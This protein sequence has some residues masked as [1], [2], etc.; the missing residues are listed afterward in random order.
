MSYIT[1]VEVGPALTRASGEGAVLKSPS[2]R[3]EPLPSS[4][5]SHIFSVEMPNSVPFGDTHCRGYHQ[6]MERGPKASVLYAPTMLR[7][8]L[9]GVYTSGVGETS[10]SFGFCRR[11]L[12]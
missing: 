11:L 9:P 5:I 12:A 8:P 1:A 7:Q 4:R 3:I 10:A 6:R 2:V